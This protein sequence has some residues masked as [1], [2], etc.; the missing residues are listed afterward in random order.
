MEEP[1]RGRGSIRQYWSR[2]AHVFHCVN[3][4]YP[5][6]LPQ[7]QAYHWFAEGAMSR[8][9]WPRARQPATGSTG[10]RWWRWLLPMEGAQEV[11]V[12]GERSHGRFPPRLAK[13]SVT[14]ECLAQRQ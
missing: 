1:A 2:G 12:A 11:E 10:L 9:Q 14:T 8:L 5:H 7:Q 3:H 6:I 4:G 13:K